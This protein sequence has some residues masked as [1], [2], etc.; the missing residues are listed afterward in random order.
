MKNIF[1]YI[2]LSLVTLS[3]ASC[4]ESGWDEGISSGTGSLQLS[5][6]AIDVN[7]AEKVVSRA[8]ANIDDFIVTVV[9]TSTEESVGQF[10]YGEM[11]EILTLPADQSYKIMVESHDIRIAEWE[12]P[13]YKGIS[14][15]FK[16]EKGKIT[17]VGE[18][19]AYFASLK[20]TIKFSDD[21]KEKLDNEAAV[22]VKG[23]NGAQ[24]VYS[25]NETRAGYFAIEG[26]TTFA[27]HFSGKIDGQLTTTETAF[28][29]VAAG[30]H[31][32]LTYNLKGTPDIPEQSGQVG[33]GD[34]DLNVD[35]EMKD[36]NSNTQMDEDILDSSDRPGQEDPQ[37]PD[38]PENPNL[39]D[40]PGDSEYVKFNYPSDSWLQHGITKKAT[41]FVTDVDKAYLE[42]LCPN[43]IKEFWVN[44]VSEDPSFKESLEGEFNLKTNFDLADTSEENKDLLETFSGMGFPT[45]YEVRGQS[46]VTFDISKFVGLLTIFDGLQT[47]TLTV[48]DELG[49]T[50]SDSVKIIGN[51][52]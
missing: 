16:I 5:S 21:L 4:D 23:T 33:L 1:K 47:F 8:S 49:N 12:R 15:V 41:D 17:K 10:I 3:M 46:K 28:Q 43:K 26:S 11:P 24:L 13:Y 51:E 42:I 36:V 9:N 29:N 48:T 35:Y 44:I 2:T 39:P 34:F 25:K 6:L 40:N 7:N 14:E 50:N 32:I 31:H 18:I 45:G 38:D 37:D 22:T 20:V 52:N 30:Q 27:A 19:T